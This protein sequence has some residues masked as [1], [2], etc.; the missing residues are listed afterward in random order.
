MATDLE[1]PSMPE[2]P[3]DPIRSRFLFVDVAA[4]RAI[5]LK[6]GARVRIGHADHADHDRVPHKLERIAMEEVRQ[7]LVHYHL[8]DVPTSVA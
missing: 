8:P 4:R 1:E 5:Q 2:T 3:A 7:G 6:R